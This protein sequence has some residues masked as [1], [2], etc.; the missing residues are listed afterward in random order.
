MD[1]D[2]YLY[3][4]LGE[5]LDFSLGLTRF[6]S[7]TLPP[8]SGE[9]FLEVHAY[10]G[11][12]TN[13]ILTI[14]R[15]PASFSGWRE[16]AEF[17]VGQLIVREDDSNSGVMAAMRQRGATVANVAADGV[18]PVS[19]R[20]SLYEFE[21]I[22]MLKTAYKLAGGPSTLHGKPNAATNRLEM[23]YRTLLLA[24]ALHTQKGIAYAEPNYYR[25][26]LATTPDDPSY[27]VQWNYPKIGLPA[28]W[29][30]TT[31]SE[32]VTVA[33]IDTGVVFDHPDLRNR[34]SDDGYDFISIRSIS[35]DGDGKDSDPSDPGDG[36]DNDEC[37]DAGSPTSSFHGT[38]VSGTIGADTDNGVGVSGVT[39]A[40]KIMPLRVLGC[41]GGTSFDIQQ[42]VL[43][44]AGLPNASGTVPVKRADIANL[45]LGGFGSSL[46]EQET[47]TAATE[48]G[49]IIIAAAG[50]DASNSLSYPA[51]YDGVVSVSATTITDELAYYSSF[52]TTID[53]SAPGGDSSRDLDGDGLLDGVISTTA[54]I[55]DTVIEPIYLPFDGTSMATP[56]VSGVAALMKAV[57]PEL[58]PEEF[59]AVL[60]NGSIV[61]D[62]GLP[63][64]DENFGYGRIDAHKAV[65]IA[66]ELA[67]GASIPQ[68]PPTLSL[69]ISTLNFGRSFSQLDVF[70]YNRG[71][72]EVEV[73]AATTTDEFVTILPP[74]SESG[75]GTYTLSIDRTDLA[76]GIYQGLVSFT[77]NGGNIDLPLVFEVIGPGQLTKGNA[78]YHYILLFDAAAETSREISLEANSG[79]YVYTFDQ[80][81]P[82][83]YI[84][85]AGSDPDNDGFVC[86]PGEACGIYPTE[87]APVAILVNQ[88]RA[89]VD[90]KTTYVIPV[91]NSSRDVTPGKTGKTLHPGIL[92]RCKKNLLQCFRRR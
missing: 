5:L 8:V 7:I 76:V 66:N 40:G 22:S 24:K 60:A 58:T 67:N 13:Y 39:W 44:A 2:L 82:A 57:Y 47:Y 85:I 32:N 38:H 23:Q 69:N 49:L 28:A 19:T 33:V 72:G 62:L 25:Y 63:G 30:V 59:D 41:G 90:F 54:K 52:G 12:G 64:L 35:L 4:A 9:Y 71:T 21:D 16:N 31:G 56:H 87:D 92:E 73:A 46:S 6:E 18:S 81:S 84:V 77:S 53:V 14:G 1:L 50:N 91:E 20:S 55:T 11:E 68:V 42:A 74:D 86:G 51:A 29:D 83:P 17:V 43:Y 80:V 45:S 34:L 89:A 27:P 15:D 70:A 65:L 79:S 61:V 75:L 78:G 10:S 26:A 37:L 48:A 36:R 3:D 88:N